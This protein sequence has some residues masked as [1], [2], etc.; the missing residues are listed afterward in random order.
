MGSQLLASQTQMVGLRVRPHSRKLFCAEATRPGGG[1][2]WVLTRKGEKV[3][4]G[5]ALAGPVYW[6]TSAA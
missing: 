3:D 6:G 2:T 1:K 5:L 4:G